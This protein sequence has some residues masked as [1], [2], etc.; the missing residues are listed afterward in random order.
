MPASAG[1]Q[2]RGSG[3]VAEQLGQVENEADQ[4][5]DELGRVTGD[6]QTVEGELATL[7]VEL[8]DARGRLR[9]AEGQVALAE[10]ALGEATD[11]QRRAEADHRRA[12]AILD[13]T[14]ELLVEEEAVLADQ[15]VESF[16]YGTVGATR[17]AMVLEV[18]RRADDPNSFAVGLKQLRVVVDTQESTVERVFDLRQER[19]EQAQDAARARGRAA[20]AAADAEDTLEFVEQMRAEAEALTVEIA[21]KEQRQRTVLTELEEDAEDLESS[22]AFVESET[23]RLTRELADRRAAEEAERRA[24]EEARNRSA[25]GAGPSIDGG[26]CPVVGA[27]AGRDF[28]NDWGYP[29]SGGRSHQGNDVFA[30]RGVPIVAVTDGV[31]VRSNQVDRGLGGITVT[32]RT[33]DGS[34][35][36][37][38]HLAT[39]APGMVPG[40][41]VE[42]GQEIGTVGN[43][44]NARTTPPHLHIQRKHGGSWVNPYPTIAPLCR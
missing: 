3:E 36:Y 28:S 2:P 32:Y 13:R 17:G 11:E 39:I 6:I 16:K 34:E 29:R 12:E 24:R 18:L 10:A 25:G 35:W 42:A 14:E 27:V 5:G 19:T 30:A 1:A 40:A 9:A 43:S 38:A 37:N 15:L 22:L 44:G 21:D 4:L 41:S 33:T 8:A 7:A 20:Q 23:A 31:V 26:Y